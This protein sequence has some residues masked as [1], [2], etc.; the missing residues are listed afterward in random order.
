[1][2]TKKKVVKKNKKKVEA[3]VFNQDQIV[4]LAAM[5]ADGTAYLLGAGRHRITEDERI[6]LLG[7][8][9]KNVSK[10]VKEFVKQ[11]GVNFLVNI[12]S[13]L[14]GEYFGQK[15]PTFDKFTGQNSSGVS[16]GH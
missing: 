5:I 13:S 14:T 3:V 10:E 12:I 4:N 15:V 8:H 7:W 11:E 6:V 2:A 9:E 1:M 16:A